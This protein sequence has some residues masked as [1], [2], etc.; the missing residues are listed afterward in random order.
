MSCLG[1]L[2]PFKEQR[3][4]RFTT[5]QRREASWLS[6]IETPPCFTF[7]E[8]AVHVDGRSHT[9]ERLSSQVLTIKIALYQPRCGITDHQGIGDRQPLDP[10][11]DIGGLTQRQLFLTS[12]TAH[13]PNH[14]QPCMDT[15]TDGKFAPF[16]LWQTL[17]QV[18][19]GIE[20]TQARAY[21]SLGVIFVGHGI[22]KIHQEPVTEQLSDMS[23]VALDKGLTQNSVSN[24]ASLT[25]LYTLGSI[26]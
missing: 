2:P 25:A 5:D 15:N 16:G 17:M 7:L 13:V 4:L 1:L 11:S 8:D 26:V 23:I 22:A 6:H 12:C 24:F 18:S 21:R 10:G 14:D 19:H 3:D 20:D 9:S